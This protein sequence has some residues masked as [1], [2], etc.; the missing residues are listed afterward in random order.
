MLPED[1]D[2]GATAMN[3]QE[4]QAEE[5]LRES[6]EREQRIR[7]ILETALDAVVTMNPAGQITDWN[8]EAERIFGWSR[9]EAIGRRMS[10]TIIPPQHQEA[11]ER[12]L[13]RFLATGEGPLLNRRIE[14]TAIHRTGREFPVELAIS[15]A[16]V[17]EAWTFSAFVRDISDRK[18]AEEAREEA[19]RAKNEFLILQEADKL[20][21]SLFNTVSHDLRTPLASVIG[22]LSSVLEDGALLDA[23]TQ[24]SLLRT[25]QEEARRLDWLV[26]NLLDMTRLEGGVIRMKTQPCD[27][28]DVVGAALLQ[29]GEAAR[30]HSVS[31]TIAPNLPLV[32]MD[33]VLIVQVLVNLLDNALRYSSGETPIEIEAQMGAEYLEIRVLDRGRGIPEEELDRVFDKFFRGASPGVPKGT[34]LGL[35]ICKGFVEAHNG[36]IVARNRAKGGTEVA[37]FLPFETNQSVM[38]T[39][40]TDH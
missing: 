36:R 39:A 27:V 22:A 31:V 20:R 12:G 30:S 13:Q 9:Q 38:R 19:N 14:T 23:L 2:E 18:Q 26:Q 25:A 1:L 5:L 37:I 8:A 29:L 21:Q 7:S 24:Q 16:R 35:S 11:H 32:P 3:S 4:Q 34:G 15:F 40:G 28:H 33:H 6:Q 10:D 17:A